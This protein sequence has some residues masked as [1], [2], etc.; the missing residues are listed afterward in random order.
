MLATILFLKLVSYVLTN[1]DLKSNRFTEH[2]LNVEVQ[3]KE[4]KSL[5]EAD[6]TFNPHEV[7][8]PTNANISN[9]LYL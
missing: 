2:S 3:S 7:T 8:Y 5:I 1:N 9:M 6:S 4:F